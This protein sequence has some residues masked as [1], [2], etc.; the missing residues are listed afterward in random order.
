MST[1]SARTRTG[2]VVAIDGPSGSGKSSTSRGVADRLGLRYLDTGAMFRAVTWWM[3][4]AGVD[5]QD[6]AAVAA[7]VPELEVK[8]GTDPLAPT[9]EV[10]GTDVA[11][12]IR[13][14]EVNAAV[15]PVSAVPEVRAWL[16]ELQRAV[17]AEEAAL[18]GIVVE[19]RDIG[20]VVAPD[21]QVKVYLTADP[22]A[23]ALRRAAEEGGTDVAATEQSLLARDKI[24]SGRATAPLVRADG[25]A[26]LDTTHHTLDEVIDQ[27]VALVDRVA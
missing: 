19:G 12:E 25:A 1:P 23:R 26:H 18:G 3:L 24:D 14:D 21:A 9:I 20:S 4:R 16:L 15:S 22:A 11:V 6:A 5:V 7:R 27:V 13:S 17:I 2:L 10:G 8:S